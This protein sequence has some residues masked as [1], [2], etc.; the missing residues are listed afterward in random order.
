M[1][2][3]HHPHHLTQEAE[4]QAAAAAAVTPVEAEAFP[5]V[6]EEADSPVV[7]AVEA[8]V[9]VADADS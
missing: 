8:T 9:A 2:A 5:A 1:D 4:V 7:A 6:A 3:V